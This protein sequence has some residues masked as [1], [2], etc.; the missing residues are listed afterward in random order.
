MKGRQGKTVNRIYSICSRMLLVGSRVKLITRGRTG[1][2]V[3]KPFSIYLK[4][5]AT[6]STK[7]NSDHYKYYHISLYILIIYSSLS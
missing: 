1:N 2:L 5:L 6:N 4:T 3:R 7:Y